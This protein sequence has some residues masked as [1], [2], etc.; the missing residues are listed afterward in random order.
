M[1]GNP[2]PSQSAQLDISGLPGCTWSVPESVSAPSFFSICDRT[3][4]THRLTNGMTEVAV[5]SNL[6]VEENPATET[7]SDR[8]GRLGGASASEE[9]T[10]RASNS[11]TAATAVCLRIA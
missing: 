11:A 7:L 1:I 2:S 6:V 3:K 10:D 8:T 9:R 4:N 5:A